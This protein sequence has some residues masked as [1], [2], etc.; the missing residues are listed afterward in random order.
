MATTNTI[1]TASRDYSTLQS[2]E[3]AVPATPT[4][5]YI[6]ECYND[7]EFTAAVEI[8][9]H[10]TSAANFIRLTAAAGQSFQDHASVRTNPLTYDQSKGVGVHANPFSV[11]IIF[12][13]D[14]YVETLR[15]QIKRSVGSY[16]KGAF[17]IGTGNSNS[18]IK[19]CIAL[20]SNSNNAINIRQADGKA[21]NCIAIDTGGGASTGFFSLYGGLSLNCTSVRSSALGAGGLGFGTYG[22]NNLAKNCASFGWTTDYAATGWDTT[23]SAYNA[24]DGTGTPGGNSQDSLT[25][26]N[27]FESTTADFRLKSGSGLIN[28]GNTDATNAPNDISGTA[29]GTTTDGDI[30]AWEFVGAGDTVSVPVR[31][32]T[33]TASAPKVSASVKPAQATHSYTAQAPQLRVRVQPAPTT[34]TYTGLVPSIT[35]VS[36]V[37]VPAATHIYTGRA[38]Q[39]KS[40]VQVTPVTHTYAGQATQVRVLVQVGQVVHSYTMRVPATLSHLRSAPA[41]HSYVIRTPGIA[42]GG[43][44]IPD[45][46]VHSYTPRA[47]KLQGRVQPGAAV[48]TYTARLPQYIANIAYS[49]KPLRARIGGTPDVDTHTR[50]GSSPAVDENQRIG[51]EVGTVTTKRIGDPAQ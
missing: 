12:V 35:A 34:H 1:G 43:T 8:G 19:D 13:T 32:H 31:S 40:R 45:P 47:P 11:A 21:I 22:A 38:P 51:P 28:T 6:G 5:G 4:G 44:I 15:L 14:D 26:A 2:W 18:F 41:V 36:G 30:G 7:S 42:A 37:S 48:H 24:S 20:K 33:Y 16:D 49:D 9:G 17:T 3:D 46:A 29:R 23:N 27:Q 50:I 25:Y 39:V 10:T